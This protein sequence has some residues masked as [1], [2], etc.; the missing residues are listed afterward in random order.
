MRPTIKEVSKLAGVSFKTVSRVLNKEKHVSDE[1]RRRVEEVVAQLNFR[2]SSA[3]RVL[4]GR[5]SFQVAL[6]YDNP[7]PH[8]IFHLQSGAQDRCEELGYRLL[9]QPCGSEA[10]DLAQRVTAL[11]DEAHLDGLILSPPVTESIALIE[12]L[13]AQG[14]PFVRISPGC[15]PESSLAV[16][17]DDVAAAREATTHLIGLGHH[18]I[19]FV[20]GP[21]NHA[22]ARQRLDGFR[23]ALAD[24]DLRFRGDLAAEGNYSFATGRDAALL[25]LDRPERPT[26]IFACNDDMAAGVLAVAHALSIAVPEELSIVGFDDSELAK[27][28]WPPLTT[29]CQPVRDL[30]YAAT[31]LLLSR[32]QR[33]RQVM[34]HHSLVIRDTTAAPG[35]NKRLASAP[36]RRQAEAPT[37]L[38]A[39][40]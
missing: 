19:G 15:R 30:A 38:S 32:D 23:Q 3:A 24:H 1:T 11:V 17:M 9:L 8:Y 16:A 20:G 7:S 21:P 27:A 33:V 14:T 28:V 34:L 25:L 29:I 12:A 37:A 26:A 39:R 18:R 2:P 6:L 36:S 5:R 4:A 40:D 22:S 10:D 13:E 35:N 31:D